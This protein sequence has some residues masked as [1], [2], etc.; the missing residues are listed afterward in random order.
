MTVHR[1]G[2]RRRHTGRHAAARSDKRYLG[3]RLVKTSPDLEVK[4]GVSQHNQYEIRSFRNALLRS[5]S[6]SLATV[7]CS[8]ARMSSDTTA[9]GAIG[10]NPA[11]TLVCQHTCCFG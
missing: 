11:S 5:C 2:D 4:V 7:F 8:S 10:Q 9:R 3:N 6:E 1:H